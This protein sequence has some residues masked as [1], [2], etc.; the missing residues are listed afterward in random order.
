MTNLTKASDVFNTFEKQMQLYDEHE[1]ALQRGDQ[2][3]ANEIA[4]TLLTNQIQKAFKTGT[5]NTLEAILKATRDL[6]PKE[7]V[8]RGIAKDEN[9]TAYKQ[10]ATKALNIFNQLEAKAFYNQKYL[11]SDDVN[12]ADANL[13]TYTERKENADREYNEYRA[14]TFSGY[15]FTDEERHINT[16]FIDTI[17]EYRA[18]SATEKEARYTPEERAYISKREKELNEEKLNVFNTPTAEEINNDSELARL[19]N[20]KFNADI[21]LENALKFKQKL[22]SKETQEAI[23]DAQ[24]KLEQAKIEIRNSLI[25]AKKQQKAEENNIK[26]VTKKQTRLNKEKEVTAKRKKESSTPKEQ[27]IS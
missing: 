1:D 25:A 14:S 22:I 19:W 6:T 12:E 2:D 20:N 8:E 7:A 9:D 23:K 15:S 24:L 18:L 21:N 13:I 5:A 10:Q 26:K 3:R 4:S 17:K 11:N 27:K 16:P